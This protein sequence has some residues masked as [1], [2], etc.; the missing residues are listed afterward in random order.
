MESMTNSPMTYR[1][2]VDEADL[3]PLFDKLKEEDLFWCLTPEKA[4]WSREAWLKAYTDPRV[5]VLAGYVG[6]ELAGFM[7]VWP[8]RPV[9]RCA[10]VGLCA[11]RRHFRQA[12][13]LCAGALVWAFDNL[14]ARTL[15][16]HVPA[17]NRHILRML[18]AVGFSRLCL[19]PG[20]TFYER[21]GTFVDGW[22]V[23]ADRASVEKAQE[24]LM[25]GET[26]AANPQE[27]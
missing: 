17:P 2:L 6:G 25:A 12:A 9:T 22:L 13:R 19:I 1:I 24:K 5:L 11:F 18:D 8:Y 10:E 27:V 26:P 20:L 21:K 3:A 15:L 23:G 4:H 7:T 16:G 14:D